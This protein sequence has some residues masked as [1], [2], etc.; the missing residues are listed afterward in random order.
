MLDAFERAPDANLAPSVHCDE[1]P[2]GFNRALRRP[3]HPLARL[4]LSLVLTAAFGAPLVAA[5]GGLAE[6]PVVLIVATLLAS[7]TRLAFEYRV[8]SKRRSGLAAALPASTVGIALA[9]G[10]ASVLGWPL[11]PRLLLGAWGASLVVLLAP[12]VLRLAGRAYG[13]GAR[14][15]LVSNSQQLADLR[16][17]VDGW[18]HLNLVGHRRFD[19]PDAAAGLG[20]EIRASRA[21]MLIL[22][23]EAIRS[24]AIVAVA[25]AINLSGVRVRDLRSFYEHQFEKVAVGDLSLAWFLFDIAAIHK[26]RAYGTVK[27]GLET[28][29]AVA[30][31]AL[32]APLLPIIALAIKLSSPGPILFRQPRVGRDGVVFSLAK[33]RTMH[34]GGDGEHGHWAATGGGRLFAVGRLLRRLRL[35]EL[36]QLFL[37]IS[38]DLSLVGPR[39]EQPPIVDRLEAQMRYYT[40]RH[41]VRP[42]ITGWAQVNL[43]YSGSD[44]GALAKLQYD[45]Y[46]VKRQS[47]RLDLRIMASTARAIV[48]SGG[49]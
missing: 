48:L 26:R 20:D 46:Y 42:G 41:A 49:S 29:V 5:S 23:D 14:L 37:V 9:L 15:F 2:P 16:A 43:G 31:V 25:A 36:P 44:A 32:C 24:P 3:R 13:G 30:V 11:H 38:G 21:T 22:S 1:P 17:E 33:F 4:L 47:L 45:L 35:D 10:T 28:A 27:R 12:D 8:T 7:V 40:A 6:A 19:V 34:T 39:P 18:S